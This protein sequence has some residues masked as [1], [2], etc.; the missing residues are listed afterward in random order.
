[1]IE[2]LFGP[3]P[4]GGLVKIGVILGVVMTVVGNLVLVERKL[5][6]W[7]QDRVGPNRAGPWG[8]LQPLADGLK[9]IFKEEIVPAQAHRPLFIM[10]P[11]LSLT[12]ALT[13]FAVIPFADR[14]VIFGRDVA[15][16][17]ADLDVGLLW[18]FAVASLGVYGIVLAGWA[19]S[20]KYS[21][22]G[23]LR[24]AAQLI[25]YELSMTLSVVG[26]LMA[27]GSLRLADIAAAQS[28]G[29]WNVVSQ[30]IGFLVFLTSAFA[31]TNRLPFDLP[32][33]EPELVAG[34][35]TEYSAMKFLLFYMA[36]YANVVLSSCMIVLLFFGGWHLPFVEGLFAGGSGAALGLAHLGIFGLKVSC[37]LFLFIWVRWTLP[38]FRYDQLMALGWKVMLPL[39][40]FNVVWTSGLILAGWI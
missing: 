16:I 15:P 9:F 19:S 23:G 34:Y 21:L 2:L 31:E 6:G 39:A 22:I 25:S 18:I 20:N 8:L 10:A 35:H 17:I 27:A 30:P 29:V 14:L 28:A 40:L 7:I 36:E 5:A 26:V 13:T 4:V 12:A 32:E 24:S 11:I 37:F 3:G 1:M 33:A 38:R